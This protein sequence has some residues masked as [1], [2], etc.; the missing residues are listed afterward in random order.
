[1][2][3][4]RL[5]EGEYTLLK[6]ACTREKRSLSEFARVELLAAIQGKADRSECQLGMELWRVRQAL[7]ELKELVSCLRPRRVRRQERGIGAG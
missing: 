5:T 7:D 2:V 4:F 1:M 6:R 3:I